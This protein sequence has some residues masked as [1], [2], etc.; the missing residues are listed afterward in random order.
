[1]VCGTT[2]TQRAGPG[3]VN[4]PSLEYQRKPLLLMQQNLDCMDAV[5]Q[6]G[7]PAWVCQLRTVTGATAMMARRWDWCRWRRRKS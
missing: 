4:A 5:L 2:A 3:N 7:R 1:L 6:L